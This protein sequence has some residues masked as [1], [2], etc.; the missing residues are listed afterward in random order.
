MDAGGLQRTDSNRQVNAIPA[1]AACVSRWLRDEQGTASCRC[2]VAG[3]DGRSGA[4]QR[5]LVG[6]AS[7]E[8]EDLRAGCGAVAAKRQRK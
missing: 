4:L 6:E 2:G 8:Q 5:H 7:P 3:G 1:E